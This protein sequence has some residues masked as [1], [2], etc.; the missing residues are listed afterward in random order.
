[1]KIK[2]KKFIYKYP[3]L[4]LG[5][6]VLLSPLIFSGITQIFI[7][8]TMADPLS[9]SPRLGP[10]IDLPFGSDIHGR[11]LF[12]A[13]VKGI[14]MTL[15]VGFLAGS[16][17][18]G[19]GIFLGFLT[20]YLGGRF[21]TVVRLITDSLMTIPSIAVMV[22]L[23]ISIE[24]NIT[25]NQMALVISSLSW[26][27]PARVIRAQVLTLKER[28][29]IE[30][31]RLSGMNTFEIIFQEILPNML[32]FLAAS[33]TGAVTG[34][35]LASVGLEAIGLGPMS[36][37]TMGMT[38]YWAITFSAMFAGMWWWWL[39]PIII[40]IIIFCGLYLV[41]AGLDKIANPRLEGPQA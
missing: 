17:G 15:Y 12:A 18:L 19:V 9:V 36:E 32:P 38:L 8:T 22:V 33:F 35:I 7:D 21:D 30:V 23:A 29:F 6:L 28:P 20:G 10:S 14:P 25:L 26:M 16:I 31:C 34:A 27:G 1:M 4:S 11:N 3:I 37:P 24:E 40:I 13:I 41:A 2:I 5:L 39:P